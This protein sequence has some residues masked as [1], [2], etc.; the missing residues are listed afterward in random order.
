MYLIVT[1]TTGE[2]IELAN[3][4]GLFFNSHPIKDH[5]VDASTYDRNTGKAVLIDLALIKSIEIAS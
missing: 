4:C 1:L 3:G 2:V 5:Q